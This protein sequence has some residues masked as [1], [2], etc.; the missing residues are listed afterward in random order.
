ML[1]NA[2]SKEQGEKQVDAM[3]IDM[4]TSKNK[5]D[6]FQE[7]RLIFKTFSF[8]GLFAVKKVKG[9][10]VV[11]KVRFI[12]FYLC[13]ITYPLGGFFLAD[14]SENWLTLYEVSYMQDTFAVLVLAVVPTLQAYSLKFITKSL[15]EILQ[16]ISQLSMMEVGFETPLKMCVKSYKITINRDTEPLHPERLFNWLP[17]AMV[18]FSILIFFTVSST[19]YLMGVDFKN[20]DKE[21]PTLVVLLVCLTFPFVSTLFIVLLTRWLEIVYRALYQYCKEVM[22]VSDVDQ[23]LAVCSYVNRLQKIFGLLDAGFFRYILSINTASITVGASLCMARLMQDNTQIV[24]IGPLVFH[25]F[26]LALTCEAGE[27][28]NAQHAELVTWLKKEIRHHKF[29]AVSSLPQQPLSSFSSAADLLLHLLDGLLEYPPEVRTG[30]Q[31]R[32]LPKPV[33]LKQ[34]STELHGPVKTFQGFHDKN[35]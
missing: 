25:G 15:P 32:V 20:V 8:L 2:S 9:Q 3:E 21:V 7:N 30:I 27:R 11:S 34:Y 16:N 18:V 12:I 17:R 14:K 35:L 19:E 22:P 29:P 28:L 6:F 31:I 33:V 13:W 26:I 10:Y 5:R 24:Y 23:V 1:P 4:G